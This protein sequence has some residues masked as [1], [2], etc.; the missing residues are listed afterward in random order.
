MLCNREIMKK[1]PHL[2]GFL[3]LPV[4]LVLLLVILVYRDFANKMAASSPEIVIVSSD[5]ELQEKVCDAVLRIADSSIKDHGF[6]SVGVSGGSVSKILSKGL[7]SKS[8]IG[9]HPSTL[10]HS[11]I[12]R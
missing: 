7:V 11:V 2:V 4:L 8:P 5:V 3:I 12:L 10:R 1:Y 6:F 9:K